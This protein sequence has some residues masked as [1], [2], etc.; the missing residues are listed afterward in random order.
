MT[1]SN[2][3]KKGFSLTYGSRGVSFVMIGKCDHMVAEAGSSER[4]NRKW[5]ETID[6]LK[7]RL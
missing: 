3:Q 7:S 1:K 2:L 5:G 6:T 4:A